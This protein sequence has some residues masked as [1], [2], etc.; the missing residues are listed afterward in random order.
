MESDWGWPSFTKP[1]EPAN[2][3]EL[4]DASL[5]IIRPEVRSNHGGSHLDHVL[6]DGPSDQG[7]LPYCIN[8]AS[9]RFILREDME[10]QGYGVYLPQVKEVG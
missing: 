3:A 1:I 7:G 5:G 4:R 6:G 2:V 10:V 8:S 9:L